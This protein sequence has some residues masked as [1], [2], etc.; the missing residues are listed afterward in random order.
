[1]QAC[2]SQNCLC[3]QVI[4]VW[5]DFTIYL[6]GSSELDDLVLPSSARTDGLTMTLTCLI[7]EI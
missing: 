3:Y 5:Q 4:F 7:R 1:M 6:C 2:Q